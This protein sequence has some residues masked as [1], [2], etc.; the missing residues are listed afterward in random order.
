MDEIQKRELR[1]L[2]DQLRADLAIV[3][4]TPLP[5]VVKRAVMNSGRILEILVKQEVNRNV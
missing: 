5:G 1:A 4:S 3:N 2:V